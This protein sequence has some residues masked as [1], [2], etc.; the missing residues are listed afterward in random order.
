MNYKTE[1]IK[2]FVKIPFF[3]KAFLIAILLVSLKWI[4]SYMHFDEDIILRIINDSSDTTY[5]PLIKTL[6]DFDLAFY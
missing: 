2:N 4:L 3:L 5:Y 1:K 6:S